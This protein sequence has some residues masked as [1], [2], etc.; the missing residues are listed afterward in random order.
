MDDDGGRRG[1]SMGQII[2][3]AILDRDGHRAGRVDD[4]QFELEPGRS[5]GDPPRLVLRAIVSGPV[6]R[7]MPSLLGGIA[8]ACY[9]LI[10]VQDPRPAVVDWSHVKAIDAFVHLDVERVAAGLRR[11]DEAVLRYVGKLP[12]AGRE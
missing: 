6:P 8:R 2:D 9:R 5:E 1:L 12:G 4:L 3:H 10:G 11:V 7:P